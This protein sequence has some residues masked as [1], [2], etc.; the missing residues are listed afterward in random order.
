MSAFAAGAWR[1]FARL[2]SPR[3]PM[4]ARR[5]RRATSGNVAMMFALVAVPLTG[6]IGLAVDMGRIYHVALDTQGALDAAALAAGRA[7]QVDKSGTLTKASA[8]A[9]VYFDQAKPKDVVVANINFAPNDQQT[10][11]T[12]TATSWVSTPFL[13]VL[14]LFGPK[15]S[16][17]DAPAACQ[18]NY[19]ACTKIVTTATAQIC[20]NCGQNDGTNLEISMMLDLTGSMSGDKIVD[21]KAAAKDLIDIV[22]WE[23]Q[24][25]WTSKVALSPFAPAVNVG[26]YFTKITGAEDREDNDGKS[27]LNIH[28]PDTC[29]TKKGKNTCSSSDY[30]D[31]LH[32]AKYAKCVVERGDNKLNDVTSG[33]NPHKYT[34]TAPDPADKKTLLPAWN[35]ARDNGFTGENT[36]T[37]EMSTACN[38]TATVVPLTSDRQ[39]LKDTIDKFGTSGSTAGQ[40]GTAFAWYLLSPNWADVWPVEST[41]TPYGTPK[42]KK[43][44]VLMTD[45]EYNTLQGKQYSDGSA[46]ATTAL[47]HAKSLCAAMKKNALVS[48]PNIEVFTVGFKLTTAA[49]KSMLKNCATDANHYYETSTGDALKAAFRDI[50]LRI[51]K[52]RLTN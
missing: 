9:G 33:T 5:F 31:V 4:L 22:I 37:E 15:S 12:V 49:S 51:S 47:N 50:A 13:S 29:F 6:A 19:Y 36:I 46:Q 40:I 39:K 48:D 1:K 23:D 35:A 32:I 7:A 34:D 8:A 26:P 3:C 20:L 41:P 16:P 30:N 38:P 27:N 10:E 52:L 11:F 24:S 44:A 21:L 28:Y 42:T 14:H 18:G 25:K 17:A 43:I 2:V 45:G